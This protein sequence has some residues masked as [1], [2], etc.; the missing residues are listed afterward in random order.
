MIL[1][2][3]ASAA[4]ALRINPQLGRMLIEQLAGASVMARV[5]RQRQV[6]RR[7]LPRTVKTKSF[8][9]FGDGIGNR[10][11]VLENAI[12]ILLDPALKALFHFQ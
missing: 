8:G 7:I 6:M 11:R 4:E 10:Q 12:S 1:Q 2:L 9:G 3:L 5:A